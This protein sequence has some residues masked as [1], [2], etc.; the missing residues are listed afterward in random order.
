[1]SLLFILACTGTLEVSII[2]SDLTATDVLAGV[3]AVL[4]PVQRVD[5]RLGDDDAWVGL[6]AGSSPYNVLDFQAEGDAQLVNVL[7]LD[8]EAQRLAIDEVPAG[9][10]TGLRL[11]L[12]QDVV[13]TLVD[14]EG[15]A[16]RVLL[17]EPFELDISEAVRVDHV[18]HLTL[19][20]DIGRSVLR[21]EDGE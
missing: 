10:V 6:A 14:E 18:T 2:R 9:P 11:V 15:S 3:E 12:V 7:E 19:A 16:R 21:D 1:M 8:G 5:A 20:V 17:E 4:L 13:P